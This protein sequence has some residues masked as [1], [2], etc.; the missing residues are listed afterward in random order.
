MPVVDDYLKSVDSPQKEVLQHIR[1]IIKATVPEAEEVISY[2]M[3]GFRYKDRY[4]V[5]FAAFKGHMSIFPGSSPVAELEDKL[6]G[7]AK[8]KG[9]IQFT[10]DN[11]LPDELVKE[12]VLQ[13]A[14]D[15]DA[16][17]K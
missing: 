2:G 14:A 6:K 8:A 5:T 12:I 7:F 17:R 16:K 15:I 9:T 13:S 1:E 11:P 10:I 3:P 4:L